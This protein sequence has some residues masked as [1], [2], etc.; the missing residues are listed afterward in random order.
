VVYCP[1]GMHAFGGGG[2]MTNPSGHISTDAYYMTSNAV[3]ADGTG[4]T[5]DAFTIAP[6]DSVVITTQCAPLRDS[7][8]SQ[9]GTPAPFNPSPPF[10][11][12]NV[13][14]SCRPGY[15]ALSGGVYL[16]K[17]DGNEVRDGLIDYS[18]PVSG[19]RWYTDGVSWD[20][21]GGDKLV[22]LEQCIR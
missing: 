7:Y 3:S 10:Q 1:A 5:F 19:N 21:T 8:V 13:Y 6:K 2:Y 15:T 22:A 17:P 4:W 16:S 18:I 20:T 9:T 11:H 14:G 12:A